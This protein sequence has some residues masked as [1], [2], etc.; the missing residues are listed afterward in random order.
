M[1]Y[2]CV[3]AGV[4]PLIMHN[5]AAGLDSRSPAKLEIASIAAKR[6]GNRTEADELRLVELECINSLY[7]DADKKPT[8]PAAA[9]RTAIEGGAKKTKQGGNVR[10]GLIVESVDAFDYDVKRYGKTAEALG[11]SAQF[12]VPVV[13]QRARILRTRAMFELPWSI[14]CTVD[15]DDELVDQQMLT[16]WLDVAGRRVGIGDWRPAKS[17]HYGRFEPEVSPITE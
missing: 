15:V 14:T 2:R 8:F 7:L 9:I 17:G 12:T 13:V 6:G 11:K 5:G 1:R 10:E 3:L 4:S 16:S